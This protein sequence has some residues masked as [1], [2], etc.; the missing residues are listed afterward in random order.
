V[1]EAAVIATDSAEPL[2][3]QAAG[4]I[5]GRVAQG[6]LVPGQRLPSERELCAQLGISR[7]TLRRALR[8]LVD[9]GVLRASHG[10]GWYVAP[11]AE[12]ADR[13]WPQALE[14]FTETARRK[15][16]TATAQVLRADVAEANL[17]E[18]EEF[19]VAAGTLL[20]VLERVRLLD[21]VPVAVDSS[22]SVLSMAPELPRADFSRASLLEELA[23]AGVEPVATD[24][25][26]ESRG[27][28][29]EATGHLGLAA[30]DPVLVMQHTMVDAKGRVVLLSAT[31]YRGDRYRL[32]TS[33]RRGGAAGAEG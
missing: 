31:T 30:G 2:W 32:R 1:N 20:F 4:L 24:T 33:F 29:E 9:A 5:E 8:H 11:R 22:R 21:G 12:K 7:V 25:M 28:P 10:R 27:C 6:G 18:A 14:S 17:D 13:E 26:I 19:E 15:S 3:V 23:R 16:L